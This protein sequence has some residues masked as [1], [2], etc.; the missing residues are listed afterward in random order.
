MER[1]SKFSAPLLGGTL[2]TAK[3]RNRWP[4][5]KLCRTIS[6]PILHSSHRF[7]IFS[8]VDLDR[9]ENTLFAVECFCHVDSIHLKRGRCYWRA[10][11]VAFWV[12]LF[13][14]LLLWASIRPVPLFL[15]SDSADDSL[16]A[17]FPSK[18]MVA[19]LKMNSI[20]FTKKTT[21]PLSSLSS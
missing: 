18:V 19:P 17:H 5:G 3:A 10:H 14:F 12:S 6:G 21:N 2:T 9:L 7:P 20:F 4:S 11:C 16:N 15:A 13:P 1:S 8:L